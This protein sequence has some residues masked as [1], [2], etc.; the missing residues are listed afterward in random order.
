MPALLYNKSVLVY[1]GITN[2]KAIFLTKELRDKCQLNILELWTYL[3]HVKIQTHNK[4]H[5]M[6]SL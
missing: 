2:F 1:I 3:E 4:D 5:K 6:H